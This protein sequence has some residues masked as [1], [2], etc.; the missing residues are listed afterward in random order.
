V[1]ARAQGFEELKPADQ[2]AVRKKFSSA[3]VRRCR[4]AALR[5]LSR[6]FV[7]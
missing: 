2:E 1:R 7:R 4:C 6:S 5:S 3:Q